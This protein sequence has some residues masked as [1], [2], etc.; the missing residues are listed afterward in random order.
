MKLKNIFAF[1]LLATLFMTGCVK[2]LPTDSLQDLQLEKTYISI[3]AEGGSV[4]VKLTAS[5]P[6]NF[7]TDKTWPITISSD[8]DGNEVK[9]PH[10]LSEASVMSGDAGEFTVS[11]SADAV[12]GG[13]EITLQIKTK[14]NIQRLCVRQGSLDPVA[15]TCKEI[16]T[17]AVVGASYL[18]KAKVTK[19]GNYATYGAFFVN[20]GTYNED[21]QIYG[22][23]S[24]SRTAYPNV[25]PGDYVEF[26]GVWSSYKNFENVEISKQIGRAHV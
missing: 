22:S 13:R 3:P 7:V 4:S 2:E 24:A 21:V 8:K 25:E 6:W 5:G 19:L 1:S 18:V 10:W 9:T 15:M 26:T 14:A 12:A 16:K 17:S 23:T 11:F 20:D